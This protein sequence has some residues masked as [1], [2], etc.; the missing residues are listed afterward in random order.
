MKKHHLFLAIVLFSCAQESDEFSGINYKSEKFEILSNGITVKC[1]N[2]DFGD[3][4]KIGDKTYKVVTE[5]ELGSLIR[6][7]QNLDNLE[8]TLQNGDVIKYNVCTSLTTDLSGVN[9]FTDPVEI[10]GNIS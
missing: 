2:C 5:Q 4:G 1:N 6:S 8:T 9:S 3:Y 10:I 7:K